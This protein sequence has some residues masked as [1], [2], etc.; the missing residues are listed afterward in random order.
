MKIKD[1]FFEFHASS[2]RPR[3]F[4]RW[5]MP[6]K[7][8]LYKKTAKHLGENSEVVWKIS[9]D[10]FGVADHIEMAGFYASAIISY[11]SDS[12]GKLRL[13]RHL[14]VPSLRFQPNLTGS[15][16]SHN[17]KYDSFSINKNGKKLSEFPDKAIIKG[18][19]K[20]IS[21]TNCD[22]EIMRE[23][24]PAVNKAALIEIITVK[25]TSDVTVDYTVKAKEYIKKTAEFISIGGSIFSETSVCFNE[26]LKPSKNR[27]QKFALNPEESY[28]FYCVHYA[29]QGNAF[30]NFSIT[31]EISA[32]KKFADEMFS[33]LVLKTPFPELDAQFSHCILRG[34]ESIFKTKS[35]LMHSP[36]GGNYYAGFGQTTSANTPTPFSP[37]RVIKRVWSKA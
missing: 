5:A 34:S 31:D 29:Y 19:L 6:K 12:K 33:S 30:P 18:S 15:S 4:A 16:F 7:N 1:K 27:E 26:N 28:T 20:I 3:P 37:F 35:G 14:T 22:T 9:S 10:G 25:N 21:H 8:E 36:G 17:F 24:L 32:R 13:M 11:G 2:L 23:L